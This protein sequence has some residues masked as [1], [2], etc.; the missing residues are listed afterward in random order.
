MITRMS[1][2]IKKDGGISIPFGPLEA[3]GIFPPL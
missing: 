1:A 3:D 2:R